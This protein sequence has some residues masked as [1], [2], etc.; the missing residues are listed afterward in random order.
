MDIKLSDIKAAAEAKY[1]SLNIDTGDGIITLRNVLRLSKEERA[2]LT[3]LQE[4]MKEEGADQE[5]ALDEILKL[6]AQTEGQGKKLIALLGDDLAA[7]MELFEKYGDQTQVGE[8]SPSQ[9]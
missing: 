3:S 8:A 4:S 2:S 5:G 6:V 1:G 9:S 7:K